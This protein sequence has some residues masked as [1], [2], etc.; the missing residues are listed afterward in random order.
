LSRTARKQQKQNKQENSIKN[1]KIAGISAVFYLLCSSRHSSL[2]CVCATKH[3]CFSSSARC[4]FTVQ[5]ALE[6][7]SSILRLADII[8]FESCLGYICF[9]FLSSFPPN[10]LNRLQGNL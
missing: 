9:L 8:A 6:R 7:I 5:C 3:T 4:S 10:D 1:K 2:G